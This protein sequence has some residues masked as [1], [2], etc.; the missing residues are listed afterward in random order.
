MSKGLKE[1]MDRI[2]ET[3]GV[4]DLYDERKTVDGLK[5]ILE[6]MADERNLVTFRRPEPFG[7]KPLGDM[8]LGDFSKLDVVGRGLSSPIHIADD[9]AFEHLAVGDFS[10][11]EARISARVEARVAVDHF[12]EEFR[13]AHPSMAAMMAEHHKDFNENLAEMAMGCT[14]CTQS[15][16]KTAIETIQSSTENESRKR[17]AISMMLDVLKVC[18]SDSDWQVMFGDE[19]EKLHSEMQRAFT[20]EM[21]RELD[22]MNTGCIDTTGFGDDC[23]TARTMEFFGNNPNPFFGADFAQKARTAE[24]QD[25][26]KAAMTQPPWTEP[27]ALTKEQCEAICE[28]LDLGPAPYQAYQEPEQVFGFDIVEDKVNPNA[29]KIRCVEKMRVDILEFVETVIKSDPQP[30]PETM[31]DSNPALFSAMKKLKQ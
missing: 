11:L 10:N 24:E 20:V 23:P 7:G 29:N 2:A 8:P 6:K 3:Q 17:Y 14:G 22:P 31:L 28:D 1:M 18:D 9:A 21:K 15:P 5:D 13:E 12:R 4:D 27:P 19:V 25:A 26:L 16:D 30:E